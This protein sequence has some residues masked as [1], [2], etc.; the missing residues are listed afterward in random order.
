M[1]KDEQKIQGERVVRTPAIVLPEGHFLTG[2]LRADQYI[3]V[4][5]D[6]VESG[7]YNK[8][9]PYAKLTSSSVDLANL[10]VG[11]K[12]APSLSDIEDIDYIKYFDP[13]SKIEKLKVVIKIRNSSSRK[14]DVVG[15][16]AR[17]YQPRG[18]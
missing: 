14:S 6:K 10:N 1:A 7:Q 5:K 2:V 8:Q 17:V 15:V 18:A 11:E 4:P 9:S 12:D 13:V 16:D 3:I